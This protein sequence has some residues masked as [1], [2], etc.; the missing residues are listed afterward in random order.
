MAITD[1]P[2]Q[3]RPREKLCNQGAHTLTD[4]ELLA[5]F[6]RTGCAGK[7][8]VDLARELILT[9]GNLRGLLEASKEQFCQGY[10]LGSAKYAQLQA[11]LEMAKRHLAEDLRENDTLNSSHAVKTYVKARMRHL[12]HE[13]FAVLF[14]DSQHQLITYD[15][16]F[17]GTIDAATVYPREVAVQALHHNAAAVIFAHNH[18][19]GNSQ[20][21]TQDVELTQTL[22]ESLDLLDIRTL[23]HLIV[24]EGEVYSF[25]EH[26]KI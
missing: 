26:G 12:P 1:W 2:T 11:V 9:F 8:A 17:N 21:S 14:L 18:P 24:G 22:K 5:I 7:S 23:D 4:T 6:L 20:P 16:L 13:T 15:E 25:A 3:D 10:G 19:S